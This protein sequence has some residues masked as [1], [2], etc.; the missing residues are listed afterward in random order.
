MARKMPQFRKQIWQVLYAYAK[1]LNAEYKRNGTIEGKALGEEGDAATA[2]RAL[3]RIVNMAQ[4]KANAEI[5]ERAPRQK[6]G[7]KTAAKKTAGRKKSSRKL[8]GIPAAE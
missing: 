2:Q 1:D 8:E 3:T 6:K 5:K 7:K 4:R